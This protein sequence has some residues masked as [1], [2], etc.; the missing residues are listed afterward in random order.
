MEFWQQIIIVGYGILALMAFVTSVYAC[1][2]KNK[3]YESTP[4]WG[5]FF[6]GFVQ[7]DNVIFGFF[8]CLVCLVTLF[9]HDW[10]LFLLTVS[11][12]WL[13][14]SIG[15]TLYW[16]F[17]QFIPRKGNEPE[18]FWSYRIVKSDA[19][20]FMNQIYWQCI[21]V[22]TIISSMYLGYLWITSF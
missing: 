19:V 14:R 16:L 4:L 21:T 20:W 9:F 8:W 10:L 3:A 11:L 7:A 17:Q 6:T 13:V 15:E 12:F 22:I 1:R 5:I 18:K 2:S